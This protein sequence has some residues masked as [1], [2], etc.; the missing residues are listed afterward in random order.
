MFLLYNLKTFWLTGNFGVGIASFFVFARLV[1]TVNIF[2]AI[3]W[4]CFVIIPV[5]IT[6]DSSDIVSV[7]YHD[8][9]DDDTFTVRNLFDG[10]V[11]VCVCVVCV[12]MCVCVRARA[13]VCMC[14]LH[15]CM[16]IVILYGG[17]AQEMYKYSML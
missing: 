4:T 8:D 16:C 14:P 11:S 1:I 10:R 9:E 15:A 3:L 17:H 5:A 12:C 6:Y 7:M 13:R 2:V